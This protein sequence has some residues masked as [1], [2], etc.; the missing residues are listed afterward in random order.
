M[1]KFSTTV[2]SL[3]N[4]TL[5]I[6]NR[7]H[8][9]GY[10]EMLLLRM[11]RELSEACYQKIPRAPSSFITQDSL[12]KG[13][14]LQG[15][16]LYIW[17]SGIFTSQQTVSKKKKVK[18]GRKENRKYRIYDLDFEKLFMIKLL[19]GLMDVFSYKLLGLLIEFLD[20]SE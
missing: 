6:D 16:L 5:S 8:S 14:G 1:E 7:S 18:K 2:D 10:K 13:Y 17:V 11:H 3:I 20:L 19:K 12:W 15:S 9:I 4:H